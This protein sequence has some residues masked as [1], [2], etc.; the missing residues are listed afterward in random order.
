MTKRNYS[1]VAPPLPLSVAVT[2]AAT[3]LTVSST[4]GYPAA[5]FLLGLE[6]GTTNEE[7][8]LC[9]ASTATTFTVT[10]AYDGTAAKTHAIGAM[11]EHTVAAIDYRE[12]SLTPM[13]TTERNAL[14]GVNLWEGLVV[15]NTTLDTLDVYHGGAWISLVR[16]DDGRLSDARTPTTHTHTKSQIT[17]FAHTHAIG[18]LPVAA[19]G[20]SNTTQVVRA[21]DARLSNA[22]TPTT[23]SHAI[24]DLP[25]AA[26][27]VSSATQVVRA[28]DA[29]LAD[30]RTPTAHNH[31]DRYYTETES[32]NLYAP[33][34]NPT[35]TGTVS[36]VTATHVGLGNVHNARQAYS[37][38]GG[39]EQAAAA[40]GTSGTVTLDCNSASV[41]TLTPTAAVT[42][43]SI[44]NEPAAGTACTITLIVSQG[45]VAYPIA[46]PSGTTWLGTQPTQVASK[47]CAIT[48]LTTDGGAT[49]VASGAV[50]N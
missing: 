46:A 2:A 35:F 17:D 50:Q 32:N 44:T 30:A 34:A 27:G 5:P 26:S 22:R 45:G 23:H 11:V 24:G 49:W 3:T 9:T 37:N 20:V 21:D 12:A 47:K 8:V 19:S 13:T 39:N 6:R 7:V 29:R 10:R 33:K 38:K 25:V 18:D 31:D 14:T 41:F 16:G 28:D 43:L 40:S 48:Y 15:S 42:T 1:N 36:G 4:A